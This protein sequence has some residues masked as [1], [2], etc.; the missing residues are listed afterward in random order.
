MDMEQLKNKDGENRKY[1]LKKEIGVIEID[2]AQILGLLKNAEK[3]DRINKLNERLKYFKEKLIKLKDEL[4]TLESNEIKQDDCVYGKDGKI[5][6]SPR[7]LE[8]GGIIDITA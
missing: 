3:E 1:E 2:V 4:K 7:E 5:T 6:G 8:I